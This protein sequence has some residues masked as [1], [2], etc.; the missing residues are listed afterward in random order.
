[1]HPQ[2]PRYLPVL[3]CPA[4]TAYTAGDAQPTVRLAQDV[5]LECL[6]ARLQALPSL[7][8]WA[9][10]FLR[11]LD[12]ADE[13]GRDA[14]WAELE[15]EGHPYVALLDCRLLILPFKLGGEG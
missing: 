1:M 4:M 12:V 13:A 5:L 10:A 7:P 6:R 3:A 11:A 15:R 8:A 14:L 9:G 2:D